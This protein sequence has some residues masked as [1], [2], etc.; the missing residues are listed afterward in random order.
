MTRGRTL[1]RSTAPFPVACA[2]ALVFGGCEGA[3]P[4][5]AA[6]GL[7]INDSAG[8][9]IVRDARPEVPLSLK[10]V[11]RVGVVEGDPDL[12]FDRV[13][14]VAPDGEGG[15]WVV[16]GDPSLRR[17]DAQGRLVARAGG[18]GRGP[19]EADMYWRVFAADGSIVVLGNPPTLQRF[20]ADGRF[21]DSRPA[22]TDAGGL[23]RPMGRTE[24]GIVLGADRFPARPGAGHGIETGGAPHAR[25]TV[26]LF[27]AP[28]TLEPTTP[29]G[30][31]PGTLLTDRGGSGP[32]LLGNPSF[33]V[34]RRGWIHVSDT[35][36]YRIETWDS[37][38]RLLRVVE[39]PME[40]RPI[41]LDY[42]ARVRAG[43]Q[44][45]FEEGVDPFLPPGLDPERRGEIE[46]LS[47]AGI[48]PTLPPH[49]RFIERVLASPR[50]D[51][52]V[53]RADRHPHPALR[54]VAHGFGYV[55]FAWHPAWRAPQVF[56][57]FDPEGAYRGTVELPFD[58]EP[59]QVEGTL[60]DGGP[61][62]RLHAV[63]TDALGVERVVVLEVGS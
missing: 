60:A 42:E 55:R 39:R 47:A 17:Y 3:A 7:E 27:T 43:F 38:G 53:E 62:L 48:P 49:F 20:T 58:M 12:Q 40:P 21:L 29:V 32:W 30:S 13:R 5:H 18:A 14:D 11:L 8:V 24:D 56:D 52:W 31:F 51:L 1:T 28:D 44:Q 34:D 59:K 33:A 26:E 9:S 23:L 41:P 36:S 63:H 54:A 45:A 61:P 57:L 22:L 25:G 46:R 37:E 10:E 15:F 4:G 2:A 35:L 50:G 19:G 6:G 16:D